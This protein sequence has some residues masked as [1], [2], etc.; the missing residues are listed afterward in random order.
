[1]KQHQSDIKDGRREDRERGE[2]DEGTVESHPV[3]PDRRGEER[4]ASPAGSA[5]DAMH[6]DEPGYGYGV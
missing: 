2:Q 1:M 3:S 5:R 6:G 4:A